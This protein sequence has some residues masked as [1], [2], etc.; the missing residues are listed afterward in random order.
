MSAGR[1]ISTWL[2]GRNTLTPMSTSRPPLI[3]RVTDAGDDVVLVDGLHDL[4]PGFDLLGLALAQGDHAARFFGAAED[5]FDVLDQHFD[6]V[7]RLAAAL[8]LLPIR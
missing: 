3:L 7:A 6:V 2:A 8:R 1:R 5:V 4:E